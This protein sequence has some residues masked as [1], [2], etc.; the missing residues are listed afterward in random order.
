MIVLSCGLLPLDARADWPEIPFPEGTTIESVGEQ[1]RLNGVPMRMHRLHL[2]ESAEKSIRFY[3][4]HLGPR[5]AEQALPGGERILSQ[6]RGDYFI[7][8]RIRPI[9]KNTSIALVSVSDVRAA[10]EAANRPLGFN[11]P[12]D[13]RVLS[14][15]ESTDAG[16]RSRQLVFHNHFDLETNRNSLARELLARGFQPDNTPS[17]KKMNSEVLYFQGDRRE[18]QLTL[19]RRDGLTQAVLTTIEIQ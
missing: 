10:K 12:A 1:V 9:S 17:R 3:R 14:D 7:T 5:L 8:L 18:A 2:Q 6:G 16:K 19:V 15:M 4:D 11:L 13:S